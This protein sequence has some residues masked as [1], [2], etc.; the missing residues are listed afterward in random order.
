MISV[1]SPGLRATVRP[2]SQRP[3]RS[4]GAPRLALYWLVVS[5]MEL[6]VLSACSGGFGGPATVAV[7]NVEGMT[8]AAA[9][10][11]ITGAGLALGTVTTVSSST[12]PAGNVVSESPAA[13]TPVE[14]GT[15]VNL[16]VSS[17]AQVPNVVGLTQAAAT[18]AITGA[19]LVLG[20]V[21]MAS[22]VTVPKGSVISQSPAA[23]TNVAPDSMVNLTVSSG[24]VTVPDVVG[25]TQADATTAITSAGLSLGGVT[26]QSSA[27]VASGLVISESPA[28]GTIVT[29][30]SGMNLVV[31]SGPPPVAVP[32]V[33]GMT[34]AS[35]TSTITRAGLRVGAVT[36]Q[37]SA[38][39]ASGLVISESPTAGTIVILGSAVSLVVSSGPVMVSVPN[40]VGLTQPAATSAITGAGLVLGTVTM[41]S[42]ATV[43]KGSVIAQSPVGG[44]SV[45]ITS[46]VSLSVS[47][48]PAPVA[49]PNV[50]GLTLADATTA[51]TAAGLVLGTVKMAR[52]DTVPSGSVI[53]Q[54]PAAGTS[55]ARGSAVNLTVSRH[56]RGASAVIIAPAAVVAYSTVILDGTTSVDPPAT[57]QSYVWAQQ[58]GPKVTLATPNAAQAS[59]TAPQV[60]TVTSFT[61]NLTVTDSLGA[62]SSATATIKVSPASTA[63]LAVTFVAARLLVAVPASPRTDYTLADGPPLAGST[64]EVQVTLTGAVQSPVFTLVDANGNVLSTPSLTSVGT[65]SIQPLTFAGSITVPTVPFTF[66]ASGTTADGQAYSVQLPSLFAPMNMSI[67]LSPSVLWLAPAATANGQLTIYNGGAAATFAIHYNDPSHLLSAGTATSVQIASGSSA[68]VPI[69][70]TYPTTTAAIGPTVTATASVAGDATRTGTATLTLWQSGGP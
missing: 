66:A 35:A 65:P 47:T 31:S 16:T 42:S 3:N 58:A 33:V 69:T 50:V 38:T 32:N 24:G 12:V 4:R 30:G 68:T 44:T 21:T 40:V 22:S 29:S 25:L 27:T 54:S 51:I 28:A 62:T 6:L 60:T 39:V 14:A 64:S 19:G 53:S 23:G 55:V 36:S 15:A 1:V 11:A 49:V 9:T 34:Q 26:T 5:V 67:S 45:A 2:P 70:V 59:F 41:A 52:S 37:S 18:T 63:Q 48:G 13:A 8:Q 61:F 10:T 56:R 46:A 20:T 43:P 17:G 7:P 57:I